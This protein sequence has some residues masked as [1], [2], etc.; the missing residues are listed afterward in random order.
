[1]TCLELI[2]PTLRS[3]AHLRSTDVAQWTLCRRRIDPRAAWRVQIVGDGRLCL[4]CLVAAA[5]R[6]YSCPV[7][8]AIQVAQLVTAPC[9][10]CAGRTVRG[11][12]G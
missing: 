4:A 9:P 3:M 8:R 10:H 12:D 11:C 1:M 2:Y 7:C 5:E 6:G